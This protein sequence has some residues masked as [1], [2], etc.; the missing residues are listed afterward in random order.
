MESSPRFKLNSSDIVPI[1]IDSAEKIGAVL[2]ACVA[3]LVAMPGFR[4]F[5][6]EHYGEMAGYAVGAIAIYVGGKHALRDK[7][8]R[9]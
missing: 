1:L 7:S 6:I 2:L 5:V 4:E 9:P 8:G 3:I